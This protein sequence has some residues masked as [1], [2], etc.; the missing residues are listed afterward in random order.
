VNND[1]PKV[2]AVLE[3]FA[4]YVRATRSYLDV[5]CSDGSLIILVARA[6][7]ADRAFGIDLDSHALQKAPFKSIEI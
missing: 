4:K 3:M 6:V 2:S 1:L 7:N 5:D